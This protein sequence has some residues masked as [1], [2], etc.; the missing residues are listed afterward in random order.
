MIKEGNSSPEIGKSS[1]IAPYVTNLDRPIFALK[2]LPEEVVAVLFAYY[3]RSP[4]SLRENLARLLEDA[5]LE[6]MEA[7]GGRVASGE[8]DPSCVPEGARAKARAFHEKWVVGYGHA[9]VA[10]HAVAHVALEDVS[11]LVSKII[12]DSRLASYTEKS[13]RYVRFETPRFFRPPLIMASR[14]A[15]R[16][17]KTAMRLFD[18]YRSLSVPL[19]DRIREAYPPEPGRRMSAYR[20]ACKA[21]ACDILRYVLPASTLTNIGLTANARTL[22]HLIMRLVSDDLQ[23]S[24]GIGEAIKREAG[25]ILPTLV[26]YA[27]P[28]AYRMESAAALDAFAGERMQEIEPVPADALTLVRWDPD[29]ED[30]LVAALLYPYARLPLA[31]LRGEVRRMDAAAKARVFDEALRRRGRHDNPLRAFENTYY[32]FD[33][34]V[35][36]GAYRDIQRHRMGTQEAQA[37]GVDHGYE[38]PEEIEAFGLSAP[39]EEAMEEAADTYYRLKGICPSEAAYIVPLAFR[40]RLMVTW[41]L[42]EVI[43]FI[44]LRSAPQGHRSYRRVAQDVYRAIARVHPFIGKYIRVTL[45]DVGLERLAAE[46]KL[47]ARREALGG[48]PDD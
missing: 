11:I 24:R 45:D 8:V 33:M 37:L 34:L 39:F 4:G 29:A 28:N 5:H 20:A 30:D 21:K 22:A 46:E 3:S 7:A 12:E 14:E 41:N 10:E 43:H 2:G 27:E 36:F 19:A 13:T 1:R 48:T 15:M 16:Y 44:E 23:E 32:T 35:D 42:R 38:L 6:G 25:R 47:R 26:K 17:E 18:A 31:Q 40:R 9:S